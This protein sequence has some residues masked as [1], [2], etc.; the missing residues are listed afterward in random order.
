MTI[1]PLPLH[2]SGK[3]RDTFKLG[4]DFPALLLPVSSNRL[5]THNVVH[6]SE[7]PGKGEL[8]TALTHFWTGELSKINVETHIYASGKNIEGSL[9]EGLHGLGLHL[10]SFVVRK[11]VV[12][13]VEFIYRN[14]LFGSLW[15]YYKEGLDPYGL[16]LPKGLKCMHRFKKPIF[17][18]TMK[19]DDGD[20]PLTPDEVLAKYPLE[21][22]FVRT[23]FVFMSSYLE[24]RGVRLIDSKYEVGHDENGNLILADEFGTGDSSRFASVHEANKATKRHAEPPWLDKQVFRVYAEKKWKG[25]KGPPITFPSYIIKKGIARYHRAF[26]LI[27]G[28]T[29]ELYQ[30]KFLS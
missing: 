14:H 30:K 13:R 7:V 17:T 8:L 3:V 9:P 25:K 20:P 10:C 28:E 26:K 1:L 18:P 2:H 11:L 24:K 27:T 16:K 4:L 19:T 29:L 21:C 5:S 12:P 6:E 15:E 23:I 22:E